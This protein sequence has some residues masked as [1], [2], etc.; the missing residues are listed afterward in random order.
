MW[1]CHCGDY[2]LDCNDVLFLCS[3]L[4]WAVPSSH[5]C[6]TLKALGYPPG[7]RAHDGLRLRQ[8]REHPPCYGQ[9]PSHMA[10]PKS[11]HGYGKSMEILWNLAVK[12]LKKVNQLQFLSLPWPRLGARG[13]TYRIIDNVRL[14]N[15]NFW[16]RHVM[17]DS[18]LL[19]IVDFP[20]ICVPKAPNNLPEFLP[21]N[22][23]DKPPV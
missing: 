2:F 4:M 13:W 23:D 1:N 8:W 16:G 15:F 18:S 17:V 9:E 20:A 14:S 10:S 11:Q 22:Y 6:P 19:P 21:V 3:S 12:K 7:V 5:L